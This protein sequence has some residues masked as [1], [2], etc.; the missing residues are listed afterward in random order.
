MGKGPRA[1]GVWPF[2]LAASDLWSHTGVNSGARL[3]FSGRAAGRYPVAFALVAAL[4]AG[5][6]GSLAQRIG[7]VPK[8]AG[9]PATLKSPDTIIAVRAV[10]GLDF[11]YFVT[12]VQP[13]LFKNYTEAQGASCATC[14]N[15]ERPGVGTFRLPARRARVA[16]ATTEADSRA[17]YAAA[18]LAVNRS[19]PLQSALLLKPLHNRPPEGPRGLDH[20][21][22]VFWP[23]AR[24]LDYQVVKAWLEGARLE[25]PVYDA[26]ALDVF[27]EK[28]QPIFTR[29][30]S[31]G[32]ACVNCHS[33]HAVL[34]LVPPDEG[35]PYTFEQ[36][37]SNYEA[38]LRLVDRA[39]PEN[40]YL[41]RKPIS[42]QE[43]AE[44]TGLSHAGG[45]RWPAGR[46]SEEYRTILEWIS[47]RSSR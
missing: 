12:L 21:G 24:A 3:L 41:V 31:D 20:G 33:I 47:R 8:Q 28:I 4:L 5:T 17:N 16:A 13:L 46:D 27:V 45:V 2:L 25:K 30:G 11:N 34:H 19:R 7:R 42:A 39:S 14:H 36:L 37:K 40:S 6:A 22:G 44:A 10:A 29:T 38:T 23:D 35:K 43:G 9:Q 15:P 32:M 26:P 18:L 1:R